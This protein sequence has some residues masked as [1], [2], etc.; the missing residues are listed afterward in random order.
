MSNDLIEKVRNLNPWAEMDWPEVAHEAADALAAQAAEIE[1]LTK[2]RDETEEERAEQ[3]RQRRNAEGDRDTLRAALISVRDE[4]DTIAARVAELEAALRWYREVALN[5]K[6]P[7]G[8]T[9]LALFQLMSDYGKR[10]HTALHPKAP[11]PADEGG[12][13]PDTCNG[14][15]PSTCGGGA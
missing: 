14:P 10:V 3:W 4:R 15:A 13:T 1:R 5:F 6:P 2:E 7:G 8:D 11:A 9:A 12:V